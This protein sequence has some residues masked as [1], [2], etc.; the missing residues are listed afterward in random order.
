MRPCACMRN[1]RTPRPHA[2][3][4]PQIINPGPAPR[5][6]CEDAAA[7]A[8]AR[9]AAPFARLRAEAAATIQLNAELG[10]ALDLGQDDVFVQALLLWFKSEF[11]SWVVRRARPLQAP[12]SAA[13]P[14]RP[15]RGAARGR[16]AAGGPRLPRLASRRITGAS[17]PGAARSPWPRS[18]PTA[19]FRAA[20]C[21]MRRHSHKLGHARAG[22]RGSRR[23][24]RPR[25][26][27]C[28]RRL[29]HG[30]ALPAVHQPPQASGDAARQARMRAPGMHQW[31]MRLCGW[32]ASSNRGGGVAGAGLCRMPLVASISELATRLDS[33]PPRHLPSCPFP[34]QVWRVG[35]LL[36]AAP[37][38]GRAGGTPHTRPRRRA[39]GGQ[40]LC[41]QFTQ[42]STRAHITGTCRR[43]SGV[44]LPLRGA[45][46]VAT[47][48]PRS[49]LDPRPACSTCG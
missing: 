25:R 2:A 41:K 15:L 20:M 5:T 44:A 1:P 21:R 43:R 14:R 38:R 11:F 19:G 7:Q 46:L 12:G 8:A 24:R 34:P 6:Q 31:R 16:H 27:L 3:S 22:A 10:E 28:M 33:L 47:P 36:D 32:A 13:A 17:G 30:R 9:R 39:R 18:P 45:V 37:P 42:G 49:H 26:R 48:T 40:G 4:R 29:R 23:R 35:A